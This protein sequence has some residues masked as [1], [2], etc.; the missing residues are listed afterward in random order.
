M[1]DYSACPDS[2]KIS[3]AMHIYL[4]CECGERTVGWLTEERNNS[5]RICTLAVFSIDAKLNRCKHRLGV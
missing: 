2:A 3:F 4:P 5:E 1:P